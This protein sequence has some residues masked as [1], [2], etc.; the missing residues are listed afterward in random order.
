MEFIPPVRCFE[1]VIRR[2]TVRKTMW[3]FLV[4]PRNPC[5]RIPRPS[6]NQP[7]NFWKDWLDIS[8]QCRTERVSFLFAFFCLSI[9]S[10]LDSSF[11]IQNYPFQETPCPPLCLGLIYPDPF[12]SLNCS[13]LFLL[14]TRSFLVVLLPVSACV[15]C[16][17]VIQHISL[18]SQV[19]LCVDPHIYS[20]PLRTSTAP[21]LF[22]SSFCLFSLS[23]ISA[24]QCLY[25]CV[26]V[27][28]CILLHTRMVVC[29]LVILSCFRLLLLF[30]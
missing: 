7:V 27:R 23:V 24:L 8:S 26:F 13:L 17:S 10:L 30:P 12:H 4:H 29:S 16:P 9:P 14:L 20:F 21:S 3:W 11:P 19:R 1:G 28:M 18:L 2:K 25:R 5:A 15:D 6:D 22:K